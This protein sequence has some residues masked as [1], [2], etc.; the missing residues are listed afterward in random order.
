MPRVSVEARLLDLQDFAEVPHAV[1]TA[2]MQAT[3]RCR[4]AVQ[5]YPDY[6][7]RYDDLHLSAVMMCKQ[8]QSMH[9][10]SQPVLTR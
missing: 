4:K 6:L 10:G 2:L 5:V 8:K 1:V 9:N 3:T 7:P